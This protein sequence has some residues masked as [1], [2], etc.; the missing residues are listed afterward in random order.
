MG[1]QETESS[2]LAIYV[3]EGR[4]IE[5]WKSN[6]YKLSSAIHGLSFLIAPP[7][8]L[9]PLPSGSFCWRFDGFRLEA[10]WKRE[11]FIPNL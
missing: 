7:F 11:I 3:V 1:A 6:Q 2:T 8:A 4:M 9:R 5:S 10:K